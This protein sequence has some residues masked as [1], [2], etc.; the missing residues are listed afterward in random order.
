VTEFVLARP[1]IAAMQSYHN[2]GG[3]ILRPPGREGGTVR[4]QD[5][6]VLSAIADRGEKMLPYYRSM[7]LYRDLYTV[8]GGEFDWFYGAR[9]ILG[10]T[11][12]LWTPK[13]LYKTGQSPSDEDEA[14]FIKYVLLNDGLV[15]W[16]E[17]DHPTYGRIEIGGTKKEWGRVPPSFLLEEECHR[18]MVFTLYHADMMPQLKIAVVEIEKLGDALYKVWVTI[19]NNR[20][21]PTRVAQDVANHISPP[22]VVSLEGPEVK[23]LSSG[24]VI[25]RFFK[26]VTSVERRPHR[27]ELDSI[28]GMEAE[29]VQFIVSGT[30]EFTITVDS[31]K[32]G[33]L[34]SKGVLP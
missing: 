12:E 27:V 8:W 14:Q 4:G 32:G 3:M 25:D 31:A 33:I 18:N 28:G 11:N 23:V 19:E 16:K 20:L 26:R 17:F 15:E 24:R 34:S 29:R 1:N 6:R 22:D 9:G 7:I 13:N 2:S 21:I 5:E 30:G 10:F